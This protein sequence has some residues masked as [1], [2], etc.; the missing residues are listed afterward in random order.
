[1]SWGV[2]REVGELMAGWGDRL[3]VAAVNGVSSVVVSG[4]VGA[5]EELVARCEAA[6]VGAGGLRWIMRRIRRRSMPLVRSWCRRWPV[7]RRGR[8]RSGFSPR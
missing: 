6:G 5:C 8:R 1:M 3:S 2:G 7:L 4:E